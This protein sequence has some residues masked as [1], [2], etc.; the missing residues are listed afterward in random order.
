[1][2]RCLSLLLFLFPVLL[3][4]Q[5]TGHDIFVSDNRGTGTS[6]VIFSYDFDHG[7]GSTLDAGNGDLDIYHDLG[8][9]DPYIHGMEA[10][11]NGVYW[12]TSTG[13]IL[14]KAHGSATTTT[15]YSGLGTQIR[16]ITVSGTNL[17]WH[18][19]DTNAVYK[20]ST[21]GVAS[22]T[23][24]TSSINAISDMVATSDT[25]FYFTGSNN[26]VRQIDIATGT[27]S[28]LASISGETFTQ[29]TGIAVYDN[30]IY[31]ASTGIARHYSMD[32]DGTNQQQMTEITQFNI[33]DIDVVSGLI[34]LLDDGGSFAAQDSVFVYQL[35]DLTQNGTLINGLDFSSSLAVFDVS[36]V[37]EPATAALTLGLLS[38][39]LVL[40]RRQRIA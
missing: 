20:G 2:K 6:D 1:M 27:A 3:C 25:I 33:D 13:E 28:T 32:I 29:F 9:D 19:E 34:F 26:L 7:V 24:L 21:D 4:A 37:P 14:F 38:S 12:T 8:G 18:D 16:N 23:V 11:A 15:L 10:D 5:F 22:A 31:A 36:A 17:F 39:L 40:R 35:S 30:K